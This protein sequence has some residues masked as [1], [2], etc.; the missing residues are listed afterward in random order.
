M[1]NSRKAVIVVENASVPRDVRVW[2][3]ATTLRDAGWQVIVI[4]P[5]EKDIHRRNAAQV[6]LGTAVDIEG[7]T[8]YRF[9]LEFAEDGTLGFLHEY[10]T[11]WFSIAR[12]SWR[13]WRAGRF[14]VI[15]FCNPP[16]IFF[17][18]GLFYR[19][20]GAGM[21][22]DHHD[23]FPEVV[24]WRFRGLPGKLFHALART[25]EY[26]TFRSANAVISTNESYR[27]VALGRGEV[28]PDRVRVVRNGPKRDQFVPVD[29]VPALKRGFAY[30]ACYAGVMG[31]EDGVQELL[32]S[33]RYLVYDLGRRDIVFNLLGDGSARPQA[34]KQIADWG[35]QDFVVMPGML[36]EYLMRQYLCTAD[37][38]LSP[39]PLTPFNARSTFIKIGE[40]MAMGKPIVAF[41][42]AESRYTAQ[43]SAIYV[44]SGDVEGYGQA[45]AALIDDPETRQRMGALG[46]QRF[47]DHLSW[48][49][50]QDELLRTYTT[51]LT[52]KNG[53]GR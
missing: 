25:M 7:V 10:I 48:E 1:S 40:Y 52:A 6:K 17:P 50:Q 29:P 4:S 15:Q 19:L 11:A 16:D 32:S 18:I 38:C 26:L 13:I 49:R 34:L 3:E 33:I 5:N 9:P 28:P 39:E 53:R 37:V 47:L 27:Q 20:L 23:L 46:R 30:S 12:L 51:A 41:D 14:D 21:V 43:E 44:P 31:N 36:D 45:I 8:V 42:L 24:A 22:F 35:L 2:Y